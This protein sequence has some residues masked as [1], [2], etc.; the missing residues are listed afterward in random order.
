[1]ARIGL[2]A[3]PLLQWLFSALAEAKTVSQPL[4]GLEG[5]REARK[6]T[7]NRGRVAMTWIDYFLVIR[8][9]LARTRCGHFCR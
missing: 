3:G 6:S 5:S 8:P 1:M 7:P 2:E 4:R 9:L